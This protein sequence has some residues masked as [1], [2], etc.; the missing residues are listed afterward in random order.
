VRT[1]K[2]YAF[3]SRIVRDEHHDL[4]IVHEGMDDPATL[5]AGYRSVDLD[6]R[7]VAPKGL[8]IRRRTSRQR[9]ARGAHAAPIPLKS[10]AAPTN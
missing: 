10:K 5:F 1:L 4:G 7:L 2:V 8:R 6:D 9:V 3:A